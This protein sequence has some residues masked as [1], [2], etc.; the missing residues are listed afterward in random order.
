[1]RKF[2]II[3][4]NAKNRL[5]QLVSFVALLMVYLTAKVLIRVNRWR[6][7]PQKLKTRLSEPLSDFYEKAVK[8]LSLQ[9]AGT[10][11]RIDLIELSV[12]NMKTKRTRTLVT[13]G[14]MAIGIGAIVFLVSIGYGLQKLVIGRVA[15]L[16]EMRQT[17]VS[18][19]TGGKIKIDDKTLS[20]FKDIPQVEMAQPL[21]AVV[22]RVNYQN[23]V[24]DMA[25][26]GVT[27]EYLKE[28]AIKPI[29]GK[30][31]ESNELTAQLPEEKGEAPL[32]QGYE[33]QVAGAETGE[34]GEKIQDVDFTI[35]PEAWVRVRESPSTTGKVLGYTKRVEG[36]GAGEEV[37]GGKY[38]ADNGGGSFWVK[39][40]VLLWEKQACLPDEGDCE[41]GEYVVLRDDNNHQV[42]E[43]GYFAEINLTVTG[44]NIKQ[45]RQLGGQAQVLGVTSDTAVNNSV[46]WV[47]IASEAGVAAAPETKT[48]EMADSAKRQ[49][50]VNRAMLKVLGI[51]ET[52]AVGKTF[53]TSFVVVGDLLADQAEKIE[54]SAAEYTIVGVIPEEKTP[55]FY[56]PF[57]DLRTLGITNY[58]QVKLVVKNQDDLAKIRKQIEAMGYLTRSVADTVE[59]ITSLF[60]TARTLLTLLGMVA[61]AVASLGMFNTLTVSLLERTR[62]VGLMKAMGMK[63]S[64]VQEL[65]LT[66]SMIMGF[67][68][69]ILGIVLG[70][71]FGKILGVIL[72]LFAVLGGVGIVDISYL[73]FSFILVILLLSLFVGLVTGIYPA[74]RATKISALNALRYE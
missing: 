49:A 70:V 9:K 3:L 44:V 19:P 73:P 61:L 63:S 40:P 23:S 67:L 39:A 42:Q 74:R 16:E 10:I 7:F 41:D 36:Q 8:F 18:P 30:I 38:E 1:M 57:I 11:S 56:V 28:S 54:S 29:E 68:G 4:T 71:I 43:M 21:I 33:G 34:F 12:R 66:E 20:D 47:E 25:V 32:R 58:S 27:N 31:F 64:E 59:Q 69:G 5:W 35:E 62:E 51:K 14:G 17:D 53:S 24:S 26:Y 46:D 13:V 55:V 72:S 22:G 52:E 65:F 2:K 6:F 45:S 37:W 60:A 50:V 48:V 15:R